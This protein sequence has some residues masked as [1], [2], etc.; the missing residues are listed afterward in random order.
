M[1]I[2]FVYLLL[3][4][5]FLSWELSVEIMELQHTDILHTIL[6][7]QKGLRLGIEEKGMVLNLIPYLHYVKE[8]GKS[9]R[10]WYS[11]GEFT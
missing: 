3:I 5:A 10:F 7:R 8:V 1:G 2:L 9:M 4:L 11:G 6:N